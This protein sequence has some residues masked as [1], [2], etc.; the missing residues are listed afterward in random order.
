M[1]TVVNPLNSTIPSIEHMVASRSNVW[2]QVIVLD[3]LWGI[4]PGQKGQ[5]RGTSAGF[6]GVK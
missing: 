3:D 4:S 5:W 1:L 6:R 2:L